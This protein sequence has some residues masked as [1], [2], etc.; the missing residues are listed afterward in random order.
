MEISYP[1]R[2]SDMPN[3]V[4]HSQK[5]LGSSQLRTLLKL[6]A[7][8]QHE[9][10]F[11]SESTPAMKL[12]SQTHTAVLEPQ[13]FTQRYYQLP[14]GNKNTKVYKAAAAEI[15]EENP[16][17]EGIDRKDFARLLKM[18]DS[19]YQHPKARELL[20]QAGDIEH[21]LFWAEDKVPCRC[22]PD[23]VIPGAI[24]DLKTTEDASPKGFAKSVLKFGY[25]F[26]QAFYTRGCQALGAGDLKF[27]FIA[28][29]KTSPYYVAVYEL[30]MA[31]WEL[32]QRQVDEALQLYR[33]CYRQNY[34]PAY[35]DDVQTISLP[36]YA[37]GQKEKK[38]DG[39][40]S[41][42]VPDGHQLDNLDKRVYLSVT[43]VSNLIGRT[44]STVRKWIKSDTLAA[45]KKDPKRQGSALE[46][47]V[48]AL[49][50]FMKRKGLNYKIAA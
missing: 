30:D 33:D 28:V 35:G 43:E 14:E 44:P 49:Q 22:R 6:P 4:Y 37:T 13:E 39:Y 12:G 41:V 2:F 50:A 9:L 1:S 46:I 40:Q 36:G 15:A 48:G 34:W 29:E 24:M 18:R 7:R 42:H 47:Q 16:G 8:F 31:A 10:K 45:R 11:S 19:V 3:D 20:S 23:K 17:K 21:S 26:Q 25:Q 32:G 38:D 27:Y 5:A